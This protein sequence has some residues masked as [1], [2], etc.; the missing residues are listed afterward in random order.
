MS[1][2][3]LKAYFDENPD[4]TKLFDEVLKLDAKLADK[5]FIKNVKF[6]NK[7]TGGSRGSAR[8]QKSADFDAP[9]LKTASLA[10]LPK[11]KIGTTKRRGGAKRSSVASVPAAATIK[12]TTMRG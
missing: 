4:Q 10:K 3:E 12:F 6:K 9:R 11:V 1:K 8:K 5:G 2:T 7:L